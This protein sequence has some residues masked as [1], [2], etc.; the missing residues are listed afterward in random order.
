MKNIFF[1]YR[2]P[3]LNY[4][5]EHVFN[6]VESGLRK[7]RIS[8]EDVF[9][10]HAR[11]CLNNLLQNILYVKRLCDGITHLTG[12]AHYA[13]LL[14]KGKVVLTIHDTRFLNFEHGLK[15]LIFKWLWFYLP[16]RKASYVTCIS[17]DVRKKLIEYFPCFK[18]KIHV[19]YNPLDANY[20][21]KFKTFNEDCPII[22]HIGTAENKN[23]ER[24]IPA[25]K[26]IDCELHIVGKYRK[27]IEDMLHF[28][29]IIYIYKSDLS[30]QEILEEYMNCDIVSFP[31]LYEGFGMPIIEGQ[32]VGRVV[33]TSDLEPMK[34]IAGDAALFVDPY[35]IEC[36]RDGIMKLIKNRH[37]RNDLI[38]KGLENIE[39]F[40][41][42]VIVKQYMDLYAKL[43]NDN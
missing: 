3:G 42:P 34:E 29:S 26:E 7:K 31:T 21:Y 5:I 25:L 22:L 30:D 27:D 36:I 4:S 18:D 33:L 6:T 41:L 20:S 8:I 12:D 35:N 39:R 32:A 11:V 43:E 13:I 10:P 15:K 37:Y 2:K 38:R 9:L 23:L 1:V 19:I 16:M 14:C 28:Y 40:K 24:L 17:N